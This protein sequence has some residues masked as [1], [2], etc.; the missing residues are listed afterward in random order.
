M[1]QP[2][3]TL[4]APTVETAQPTLTRH[5]RCDRCRAQAFVLVK[6]TANTPLAFCG[7]HYRKY[8]PSLTGA[9][10]ILDHTDKINAAPSPT[11]SLDA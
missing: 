3:A 5:D 11:Q 7:H 9:Q 8:Q 4:P 6:M 1:S 2:T 10:W